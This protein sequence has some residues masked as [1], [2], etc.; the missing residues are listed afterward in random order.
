MLAEGLSEEELE[1][2]DTKV[3]MI[4]DPEDV[5]REMLRAHQEAMGMVFAEPD[6]PVD[7]PPVPEDGEIRGEPW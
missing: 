5:A 6:A 3:G 4:T 7:L 1:E 2:L